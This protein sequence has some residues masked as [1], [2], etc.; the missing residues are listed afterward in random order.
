MPLMTT[1]AGA[2][3]ALVG[4]G[5]FNPAS[6][7]TLAGW[8]KADTGA[9]NNTNLTGSPSNNTNIKSVTDQS[10]LG[11]HLVGDATTATNNWNNTGTNILNGLPTINTLGAANQNL[12]ASLALGTNVPFSA[13][14]VFRVTSSS[15][16]GRFMS[17][18]GSGQT[19][20]YDNGASFEISESSSTAHQLVQNFP[21]YSPG[22]NIAGALTLGTWLQIGVVFDGTNVT[23]Y[24][25]GNSAGSTADTNTF[26]TVT[27]AIGGHAVA[28]PAAAGVA[29]TGG[30][31]EVLVGAANWNSNAANI[32]AYLLSR[33]GV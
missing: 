6:L 26:N 16:V 31:A 9:W 14:G 29:L 21:S 12:Q 11:N 2:Y 15:G 4:G 23:Y 3:L 19:H 1:G 22:G 24:S 27:F 30:W 13:F 25:A 7:P 20:D 32:K 18:V 8:W 33:W 10:G 5:S 28:A 17:A